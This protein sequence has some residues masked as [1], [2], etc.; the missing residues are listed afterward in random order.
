MLESHHRAHEFFH[1]EK[2]E[3]VEKIN[4]EALIT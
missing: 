1:E 3:N 2:G 4:K